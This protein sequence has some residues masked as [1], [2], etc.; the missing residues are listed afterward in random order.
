MEALDAIGQNEGTQILELLLTHEHDNLTIVGISLNQTVFRDRPLP[1]YV[2][3][4]GVKMTYLKSFSKDQLVTLLTDQAEGGGVPIEEDMIVRL[5]TKCAESGNSFTLAHA[6]TVC[7]LV[8][9]RILQGE[10]H[11][12]FETLEGTVF[13]DSLDLAFLECNVMSLLDD[14]PVHEGKALLRH[15]LRAASDES[16]R[17]IVK[18]LNLHYKEIFD[19]HALSTTLIH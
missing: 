4:K 13:R 14:L 15:V 19:E 3:E 11:E 10:G 1:F 16:K 6:Q 9:M 7:H 8:T 5:A 2:Q 12:E 18:Y 17:D